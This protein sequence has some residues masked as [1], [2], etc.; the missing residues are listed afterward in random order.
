MGRSLHF[1]YSE[2]ELPY[3]SP[4]SEKIQQLQTGQK[5]KLII[6]SFNTKIIRR[7]VSNYGFKTSN[8]YKELIIDSND[9]DI[10]LHPFGL[11]SI[12]LRDSSLEYASQ[13]YEWIL[14]SDGYIRESE[15]YGILYIVNDIEIL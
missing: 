1:S 10:N 8:I 15:H 5:I 14:T 2:I 12:L 9:S 7:S 11:R 3:Q 13:F 6:S 4:A